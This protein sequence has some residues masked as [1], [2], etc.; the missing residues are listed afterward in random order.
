MLLACTFFAP[1]KASC[2]SQLQS[3]QNR[4]ENTFE[5]EEP[6]RWSSFLPIWGEEARKRGYELPLPFGISANFY[7]EKQ[8]FEVQDLKIAFGDGGFRSIGD[9]IQLGDIDTSQSNY[10]LR[11]D[12]WLLPFFNIYG[13]IGFTEGNMDGKVF[14]PGRPPFLPA[15]TIPLDIDYEG[16]TYGGGLPWPVDSVCRSAN[17]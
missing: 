3:G 1:P 5:S 16:P 4:R 12:A 11:L 7:S 6:Q 17:R 14:V 2:E 13:L 15:V 9:F 10:N 8:D